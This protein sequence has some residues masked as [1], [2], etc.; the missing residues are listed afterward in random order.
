MIFLRAYL[1]V[2]LVTL[3]TW[4]VAND[5]YFLVLFVSFCLSM[6]WTFNVSSM[7]NGNFFKKL[8]YSTGAVSGTATA[9][10]IARYL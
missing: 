6:T 2:L 8:L 3:N 7:A 10:L 9:L 5:R 4:C 1:L